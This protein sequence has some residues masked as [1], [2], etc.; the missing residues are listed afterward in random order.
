MSGEEHEMSNEEP[1]PGEWEN[2]FETI[3]FNSRFT[4]LLAVI[5]ILLAAIVMFIKGCIEVIQGIAVF[6]PDMLAWR[7]NSQDDTAIILS[8]IP[9]LENYLFATVLLIMSMGLYELFISKINP[10]CRTA[11]SRPDHWLMIRDLDDLKSKMGEIVIMI[12]IVNFFKQ[13]FSVTFTQPIDLLVFGASIVL[14]AVALFVTHYS[15]LR[16]KSS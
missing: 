6:L 16:R 5:G 13:S 3:L 15:A 10:K 7:P 11:G 4:V 12:L 9:A 8:F 2:R 1:E 14:V